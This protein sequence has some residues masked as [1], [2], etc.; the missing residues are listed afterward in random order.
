MA[1]SMLR[2]IKL[3]IGE[4]LHR[5]AL[6]RALADGADTRSDGRLEVRA[7]ALTGRSERD[8]VA[9]GIEKVV[10]NAEDPN[11]RLSAAAPVDGAAVL[12][13][14]DE[15]RALAARLRS[16]EPV[17]ARGIAL[18]DVLLADTDS[19]LYPPTD[20]ERLRAAARAAID[21]LHA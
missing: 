17:H 16:D 12:A 13:A 11:F 2:S 8:R 10:D 7:R 9:S 15:L 1:G 18:A 21:A 5:W 4:R 3:R 6:T 20:R 14:R 19:A